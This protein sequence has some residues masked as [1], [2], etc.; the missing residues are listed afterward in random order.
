MFVC[1]KCQ[2]SKPQSD[3]RYR[4][5]KDRYEKR[6]IAC[7][8]AIN[9]EY[10][11]KRRSTARYK[12]HRR[13]QH[14]GRYNLT[15]QEYQELMAA[16]GNACAVCAQDFATERAHIDHDHKC[17]PQRAASCGS[18][19]RGLLCSA[20]N[21]TLGMFEGSVGITAFLSYILRGPIKTEPKAPLLPG[22]VTL[23]EARAAKQWAIAE[24]I[25]TTKYGLPSRVVV[26]R[27][28][29]TMLAG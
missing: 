2:I 22:E 12:A 3:F 10:A 27:Y 11:K 14:L 6:C 20:C 8:R 9:N 21:L 4:K 25:M 18:C 24:G 16:Q 1:T 15:E 28:R 5:D 7:E 29:R 26:D 23:E 13:S 17:C 19:I